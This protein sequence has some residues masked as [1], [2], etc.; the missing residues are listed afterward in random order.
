MRF[1]P[2][3]ITRSRYTRPVPDNFGLWRH[4]ELSRR[5]VEVVSTLPFLE[6]RVNLSRGGFALDKE[7]LG[8]AYGC[9]LLSQGSLAVANVQALK[10]MKMK[11]PPTLFSHPARCVLV[12]HLLESVTSND[13]D[14]STRLW[15]THLQR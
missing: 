12:F 6:T 10:A 11:L 13:G 1:S 3:F 4:E 2:K 14:A 9:Y 15:S 5:Q 7:C 8:N